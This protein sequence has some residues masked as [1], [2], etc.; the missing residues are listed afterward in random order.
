MVFPIFRQ[1]GDDE[2]GGTFH[3]RHKPF[4]AFDGTVVE[5]I[6]D[7]VFIPQNGQM[8]LLKAKLF[9]GKRKNPADAKFP[10]PAIEL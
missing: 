4:D 3:D 7:Q 9:S 2:G 1:R 6:G 10:R 5:A 8:T